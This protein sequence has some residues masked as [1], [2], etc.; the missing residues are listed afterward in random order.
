[1]PSKFILDEADVDRPRDPR[2]HERSEREGRRYTDTLS[3]ITW[4]L[5]YAPPDE[6]IENGSWRETKAALEE[7]LSNTCQFA[8]G[9]EE[10]GSAGRL[11][12]HYALWLLRPRRSANLRRSYELGPSSAKFKFKI[13][14]SN[15][16]HDSLAWKG[17]LSYVGE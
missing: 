14:R 4:H 12:F 3:S 17:L 6:E 11:H 5:T 16:Q 10:R 13:C 7:K 1:M 9:F 15:E 2:I 8:I